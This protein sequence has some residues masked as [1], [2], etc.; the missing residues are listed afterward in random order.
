[1][2][3]GWGGTGDKRAAD[4]L[5]FSSQTGSG[6]TSLFMALLGEMHFEQKVRSSF[7]KQTKSLADRTE[8][9]F[10]DQAGSSFSLP[11]SGGV[12]Y[13]DQQSWL[14]NQT[15]RDNILFGSPYDEERYTK[16]VEQC[17]L[18]R[19]FSLFDAGD[20]TEVGGS[21]STLRSPSLHYE[22]NLLTYCPRLCSFRA[23]KG[24]TLSGGQK[25]RITLARGLCIF[26][27]KHRSEA[28][29]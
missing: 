11:R 2:F 23:E 7:S 15:L 12:A 21:F 18:A 14:Q 16:V 9:L 5:R 28:V 27:S 17:A 26:S 22:T 4:A 6:K 19:D 3:G 24:L 25:A 20:L 13:A 1:M 10:L 8:P 29:R